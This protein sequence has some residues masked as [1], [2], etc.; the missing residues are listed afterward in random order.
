MILNR[1]RDGAAR[2][3]GGP[4]PRRP[5]HWIAGGLTMLLLLASGHL[6]AE[7]QQPAIAIIIDDMGN[8]LKAGRRLIQID[9]PLTFAFLPFRPFTKT[10]ATEAHAAGKEN[11]MHAPMANTRGLQ[12]GAGALQPGMT[13]AQT[14]ATINAS[15]DEVPFV[16]GMNNHMGSLLTQRAEPMGWVMQTLAQRPLYFV[17]SRTI[18]ST[19]AAD[20]AQAYRIPN[21]SRDVFLDDEQTLQNVHQA[22]ERLLA[23]ARKKGS[24]IAIGHPHDVTVRYLEWRLAKMDQEGIAVATVSA[25]WRLR[26]RQTEMF[27]DRK[28][29]LTNLH[30]ARAHESLGLRDAVLSE[31]KD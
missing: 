17:D 20:V 19:V 1:L 23:I 30:T 4:S 10:L 25:L 12:L 18:A 14:I 29:L 28:A 31:V 8:N 11:M 13:A 27:A 26:H 5:G 21:L 3:K 2:L 15:L 24:A 7:H 22:F 6:H 9:S 16:R